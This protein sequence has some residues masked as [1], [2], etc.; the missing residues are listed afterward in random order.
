MPVQTKSVTNRRD[1]TLHSYQE[2]MSEA[3]SLA[4]Q[5][6]ET[7]GNWSL[8]QIIEHLAKSLEGSIDG[9][10]GQAPWLMR[11]FAQL[12][13][14]NRLLH[15]KLMPGFQIPDKLRSQFYPEK[16]VSVDEALQHLRKAI[17]RCENESQRARHPALGYLNQEEWD[18]F[19]LRHA[20]MHFSFVRPV[21]G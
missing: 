7:L 9:I 6:V 16:S 2:M 5:Q 1:V 13:L 15:G 19:S 18:L 17:G 21:A 14:R 3:E 8:A 11:M 12:F 4:G 20:E 10:D